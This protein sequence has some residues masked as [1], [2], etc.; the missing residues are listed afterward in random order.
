MTQLGTALRVCAILVLVGCNSKKTTADK[1]GTT[2]DA[3]ANTDGK[4]TGPGKGKV[5]LDV[6]GKLTE[7]DATVKPGKGAE[8]PHKAH[9]VRLEAGKRYRINVPKAEFA[10]WLILRDSQGKPLEQERD[11][12]GST[13]P[14]ILFSPPKTDEYRVLV[15]PH[16]V[17][18]GSYSLTVQEVGG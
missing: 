17:K 11:V 5:V 13:P 7:T 15:L 1:S 12:G 16:D 9:S 14:L 10:V 18:V 6:S 2:K 4:G 8:R 3:V